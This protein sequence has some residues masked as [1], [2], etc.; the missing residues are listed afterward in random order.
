MHLLVD[1]IE[2]L[3][4]DG[5]TLLPQD[6]R[7]VHIVDVLHDLALHHSRAIVVFYVTLPTRLRHVTLLVKALLLE[8]LSCIVVCISQEILKSLFLCM[9]FKFVHQASTQ[10]AHLLGSCDSQED[11]F[12]ELL[13]TERSEHASS[14]DLRSLAILA[15]HDDHGLVLTVHG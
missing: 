15:S 3:G 10:S 11:D 13:S 4:D 1:D 5:V 9:I 14:K 7:Y 12:R 6:L 8:K 2:D